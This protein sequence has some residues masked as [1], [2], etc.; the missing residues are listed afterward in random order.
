MISLAEAVPE[1][2]RD[3]E[4][5]RITL[6]KRPLVPYVLKKDPVQEAVSALKN[7]QSLKTSIGEDTELHLPIWH[8]GTREAF[9]MHMNMAIDAIKK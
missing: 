2:I 9:L 1:G 7:Y 5:K 6:Y 4:C 3:R 8:C